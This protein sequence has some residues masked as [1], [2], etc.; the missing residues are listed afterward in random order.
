MTLQK[1]TRVLH[2]FRKLD[3]GG[4]ETWVMNV[5]RNI[6][7]S[8]YQFHFLVE[9]EDPGAYDEEVRRL[10]GQ[11]HVLGSPRKPHKYLRRLMGVL[12]EYG[13]DSV[14]HSHVHHFSGIPLTIA[15]IFRIPVRI[16]HSHSDLSQRNHNAGFPRRLYYWVTK[17][18][19]NSSS[20]VGLAASE[21][22]AL[23]LFGPAWFHDARNQILLCGIDLSAYRGGELGNGVRAHLGIDDDSLVLT[24]VGRFATM[25]NHAF[26]IR[27][28]ESVARIEPC[29]H[30]L[31]VGDGPL[32]KGVEEEVKRRMLADKVTFAGGRSDVPSILGSS[33]VFVFPSLYEGLGLALVEAQAAGVPCVLSDVIP[34]EADVIPRLITRLSLEQS[35]D[36]WADAVLASAEGRLNPAETLELVSNSPFNIHHS[37]E[38]LVGIY[39]GSR[40]DRPE[41][42][43]N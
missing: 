31:L 9:S 29:A 15:R 42:T 24:H 6:D 38:A 32:R 37:V 13:P 2:I 8:R 19:I 23:S 3:R 28:F 1:K 10:G 16:A 18:L 20:T 12:K 4:A 25:K 27:V 26:L 40:A 7:R 11:I 22:A 43:R 35:P 17:W 21:R 30:L 5:Y 33:D 36:D 34:S 41:S 39:T 14:V